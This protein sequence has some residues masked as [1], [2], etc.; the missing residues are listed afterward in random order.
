[1]QL[2]KSC[3]TC[4]HNYHK[5]HTNKRCPHILMCHDHDKWIPCTNRE[6]LSTLSVE[7][8]S[9]WICNHHSCECRCVGYEKCHYGHNGIQ[10]WLQS[11]YKEEDYV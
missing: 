9:K 8:L 5:G 1:M 4:Y 7:D 10:D 11:P 6:Y 3:K 2:E